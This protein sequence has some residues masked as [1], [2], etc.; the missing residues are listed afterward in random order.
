MFTV[1]ENKAGDAPGERVAETEEPVHVHATAQVE[2][3]GEAKRAAD[4]V[5][6]PTVA[7]KRNSVLVSD[8][9]DE[10]GG[11][12]ASTS[13]DAPRIAVSEG[14]FASP[15]LT[16]ATTNATAAADAH[17]DEGEA[18]VVLDVTEEE[19]E[20]CESARAEEEETSSRV[21][22]DD[23]TESAVGAVEKVDV[24]G[25]PDQT[26]EAQGD[27][28]DQ[29]HAHVSV[30]NRIAG[31]AGVAE[32]EGEVEAPVR[33]LIQ[34]ADAQGEEQIAAPLHDAV[35]VSPAPA[36]AHTRA[37]EDVPGQRIAGGD[38]EANADSEAAAG[39]GSEEEYVT[40]RD[41]QQGGHPSL[42]VLQI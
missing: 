29:R 4:V 22:R 8:A 25:R 27:V 9:A 17:M 12:D 20:G 33:N 5:D 3:P 14:L 38:H 11:A 34:V 6:N 2:S 37:I 1:V 10:G 42:L 41:A 39:K 7:G 26:P 18:G 36:E 15:P 21:A 40:A 19:K 16:D 23:G 13:K 32:V 35:D 24:E 30:I 31:S 28:M